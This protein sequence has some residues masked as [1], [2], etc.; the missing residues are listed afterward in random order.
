MSQQENITQIIALL[1]IVGN[2]TVVGSLI[3][4]I[5][6]IQKLCKTIERI[7]ADTS[8]GITFEKIKK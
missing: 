5:W 2:L 4:L 1:G 8:I 6:S 7:S 3:Y